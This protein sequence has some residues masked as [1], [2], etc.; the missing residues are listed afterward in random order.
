MP[1]VF[2]DTCV[3]SGFAK[4]DMKPEDASAFIDMTKMVQRSELTIWASTV[5]REEIDRV[6]AEY[7]QAHID[8]YEALRIVRASNTTWVDTDPESTGFGDVVENPHYRSL[9]DI[10]RDENDARLMFQAK[11]A[12]LDF[13][14]IDY[15]SIL[16]RAS[17]VET[18]VGVSAVSPSEYM[19]QRTT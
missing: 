12:G 17:E 6:P 9:R 7:R 14:T 2:V 16:N 5:A 4:G 1:A 11:M 8:E 18:K 10:L 3:I 15:K 13:V 19:S